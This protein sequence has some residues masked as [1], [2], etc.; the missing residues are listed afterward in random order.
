MLSFGGQWPG[1]PGLPNPP[2]ERENGTIQEDRYIELIRLVQ[3]L[4]KRVDHLEKVT[5]VTKDQ[6]L[7]CELCNVLGSHQPWCENV[8]RV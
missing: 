2:K 6:P 5:G 4:K 3:A 8:K 7:P 1:I